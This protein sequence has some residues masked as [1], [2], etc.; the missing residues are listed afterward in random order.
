M[1]VLEKNG[2]EYPRTERCKYCRS[3]VELDKDDTTITHRDYF[4][5]GPWVIDYQQHGDTQYK[6]IVSDVELIDAIFAMI[7]KLKDEEVI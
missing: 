1:K 6:Y 5:S 7:V 2:V 3:L 4:E